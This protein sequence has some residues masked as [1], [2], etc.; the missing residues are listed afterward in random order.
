MSNVCGEHLPR[1]IRSII[2]DYD[3]P[4][5]VYLLNDSAK[6]CDFCDEQAEFFVTIGDA[7]STHNDELHHSEDTIVNH[8]Y[9][10]TLVHA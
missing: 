9:I 10:R 3:L 4:V 5:E 8:D 7:W 1:K 6:T 2:V